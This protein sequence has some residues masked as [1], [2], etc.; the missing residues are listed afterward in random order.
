MKLERIILITLIVANTLLVHSVRECPAWVGFELDGAATAVNDTWDTAGGDGG[1]WELAGRLVVQEQLEPLDLELHWLA[2][3]RCAFGELRL[4]GPYGESPFRTLDMEKTHRETSR[5]ALTSEVD[6]LTAGWTFSGLGI[7]VGR[8][9]ITWGEAYYFNINDLFGAFP[10]TETNRLYKPGIDALTVTASL[11]PFSDLSLVTVPSDDTDDNAAV[12]LQ[13]P[14]GAG[15]LSLTGGRIREDIKLGAGYTV[16]FGGAR[17]YGTHL[18]TREDG[19]TGFSETVAGVESQVGPYTHMVGEIYL[20]GWGAADPDEYPA[21]RLTER[22]LAGQALTLGRLSGAVQI[23]RQVTPLL[24]VTPAL[25]ANLSDGSVLARLDG[26]WSLSDL[27]SLSGGI[28]V[29]LG[30]RPDSGVQESEYGGAPLT[31]YLELVH[32]I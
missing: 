9:A 5:S 29:G 10:I 28:F 16:D 21:L 8:Q 14:V 23:S 31:V 19:G 6:R 12:N 17:I 1:Q 25:F 4:T 20:N 24:T 27:T 30:K 26:G 7:T 11:G 32:S 3:A 13:I 2:D 15:S 18:V 22:Y